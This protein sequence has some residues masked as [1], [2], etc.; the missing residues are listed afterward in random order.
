MTNEKRLAKITKACLEIKERG[1]L[2]FWIHVEYE[3]GGC[4]GVGG[5]ALD[6]YDKEKKRRTGTA[7]G[8]E[9]IRRLLI[10]LKV[11]DFSEM[12]GKNIWVHGVGE[13][14][15][16]KTSGVSSLY[17]ENKDSKPVIFDDILKEF[18]EASK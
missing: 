11:N 8:C 10:E 17:V 9:V 18:N 13:G 12:K 5:I 16:F 7:Y 1:I 6:V 2:N 15:Q 3:D 14:F 4:Q